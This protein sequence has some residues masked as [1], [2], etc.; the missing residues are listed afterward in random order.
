MTNN[1]KYQRSGLKDSWNAFMCEGAKY[2]NNDI[3]FCPTIISKLPKKII[4]WEEAK[5][6]HKKMMAKNPHYYL[7]AFVC[8][9][10]DDYKFDGPKSSIWLFP[11][12]A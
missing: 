5:K 11:K 3:P 1:T 9:Y 12:Q 8:T 7:D 4:T 2:S 10:I 6:I